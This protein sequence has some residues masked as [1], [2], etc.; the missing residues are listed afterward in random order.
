[1]ALVASKAPVHDPSAVTTFLFT[2]IEGSTR[3]W[4]RD[5]DRM[6]PALAGHDALAQSVVEARRGSIVKMTG[7]GMCAAFGDPAD[8]LDAVAALQLALADP[9]ATNGVTLHVR[10]GLHAGV[11]ERRDNDFFGRVLNRAARI[12]AAAH[13]GQVLMSEAVAALVSERLARDVELRDLGLVRLRDLAAPERVFQLVHPRLRNDFP[14]LRSLDARPN[15]LPQQVTSFV[16]RQ[17]ELAEVKGWLAKTRLLTLVGVGGLG[18]TRLSLQVAADVLDDYP[19]G[20]W[21]VELAPLADPHRVAQAAASVLGVV[22]DAGRPVQEALAKFVK[23]RRLLII[24][25][26]CEHLLQACAELARDLLHAGSG[27]KLLASSREPLH[28]TGEMSYPLPS[29]AVP[30]RRRNFTGAALTQFEAVHLFTDRAVA[31]KPAFQVSDENAPAIAEICRC[32]DGIPLALELAAARMR[33]LSVEQI[34]ARLTDRFRLLTSGDRTAM[35]RQQTLRACIDWSYELLLAPERTLLERLSVFAGGWTL[36]SAEAVGAGGEIAEADVLDLLTRLVDKSLAIS[37]AEG[38]RYQLLETVR[39]Y[40]QERL[41]ESADGDAARTRHL[42]FFLALAERARPKL[43]GPEQATW[44]K[45]IDAD[46]ENLLAAHSW[47]DHAEG[48]A[49]LGLRLVS[50]IRRYLMRRGRHGLGYR[51]AVEALG[52]PGAQERTTA[53]SRGL[54]DVGQLASSM[55]RYAEARGYLEESLAIARDIGDKGRVALVLQPLGQAMLGL[56]DIAAARR[57]LR[58]ALALAE[59]TGNKRE[60]AAALNTLAQLYRVEGDL[61]AAEPLYGKVLELVRE[62]GDRESAAIGLLNLAMVAVGRG[63][64]DRA[65]TMLLEVISI[66]EETGSNPAGQSLLEV[67]A[68]LA[69]SQGDWE[70]AAIFYAAAEAQTGQSGLQRDPAD[71]AFLSP[72]IAKARAALGAPVFAALVA[73]PLSFEDAMAKTRAWLQKEPG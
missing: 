21:F 30:D 43:V 42:G 24:L 52:R 41:K 7:D 6:R 50:S 58:E 2:D 72:L 70:H 11:A 38:G 37:E 36:E 44:L 56:G 55:G 61:T 59:E 26:N 48:G 47:C 31:A 3:L 4:E 65:R 22:E 68:G 1:L 32:L 40:A 45:R 19:D 10:C 51:V 69:S 13:G 71:E 54:F 35:P 12:M 16:G 15:N 9:A 5:A 23:D 66:V 63:Q 8:A 62:L 64:P 14:A 28:L 57:H 27:V 39:Q 49:E 46:A 20:V 33:A 18:K 73:D 34:A 29:L 17:R 53:R 60:V 67:S 25:D